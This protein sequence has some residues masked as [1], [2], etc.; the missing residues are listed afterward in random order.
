MALD[1]WCAVSFG[2]AGGFIGEDVKLGDVVFAE[3]VYYYEPAKETV[4]KITQAGS[5]TRNYSK[6]ICYQSA[7]QS[8]HVPFPT[9]NLI[10]DEARRINTDNFTLRFGP[11]ASGEKLIADINSSARAMIL[12]INRKTLAVEME[13]AG[14]GAAVCWLRSEL[15]P[16][17]FIAIKG[18]SD[19]ATTEKNTIPQ[20]TKVKN[21]EVAVANASSVLEK[22]ISVLETQRLEPLPDKRLEKAHRLAILVKQVL[23]EIHV[24]EPI[25]IVEIERILYA[26]EGRHP[27]VFYHWRQLHPKLHWVDFFFLKV[28]ERLKDIGFTVMPLVTNTVSES[29][30]KEVDNV[31][32]SILKVKPTYYSE[33]CNYRHKYISYAATHGFSPEVSEKIKNVTHIHGLKE[34]NLATEEWLQYIAWAARI[35]ERCMVLI[36]TKHYEIYLNLFKILPLHTCLVKTRDMNLAGR[37]GKFDE[38]GKN[39]FIDPPRYPEI[40][41]WV[42]SRP[43]VN[44]INE[45]ISHLSIYENLPGTTHLDAKQFVNLPLTQ[46]FLLWLEGIDNSE[47]KNAIFQLLGLL[48]IWNQRYF[49]GFDTN[50][51]QT[52]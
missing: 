41:R 8:Q 3:S 17:H 32:R 9:S 30:N 27:L 23:S 43:P 35:V 29:I 20:E 42:Q 52:C 14:V 39:L 51:Q 36:W 47:R 24:V 4:K 5:T 31:I 37:L 11:V 10:E 25:E 21:R 22:L 18:I 15:K 46:D 1:P 12:N 13:A 45:F 40:I 33:V 6:R 7:S 48:D 16:L 50:E 26:T 44:Q 28:L 49:K 19:D 2:I 34:G 38:P